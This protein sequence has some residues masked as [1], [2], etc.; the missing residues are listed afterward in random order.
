MIQLK[1]HS[2]STSQITPP[3]IE[4]RIKERTALYK[5]SRPMISTAMLMIE[6]SM[7]SARAMPSTKLLPAS[8]MAPNRPFWVYTIKRTSVPSHRP[9]FPIKLSTCMV[10]F[11]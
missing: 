8:V 4:A 3:I 1:I 5:N 7:P 9:R 11:R 2:P 10:M 6:V